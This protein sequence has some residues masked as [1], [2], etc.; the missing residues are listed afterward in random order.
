V[1]RRDDLVVVVATA[2][3][4]KFSGAMAAYHRGGGRLANPPRH[5]PATLDAVRS[6]L[7]G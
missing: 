5:V 6:A 3:A 7:S 2:H 4:L 1:I